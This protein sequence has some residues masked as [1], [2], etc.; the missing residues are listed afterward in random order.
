MKPT[1]CVCSCILRAQKTRNVVVDPNDT[2]FRFIL[3]DPKLKQDGMFYS[4]VV[5]LTPS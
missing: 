4:Y 5:L 3:L 2:E 1:G